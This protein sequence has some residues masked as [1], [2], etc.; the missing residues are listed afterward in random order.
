MH[1][2]LYP[3]LFFNPPFIRSYPNM[4]MEIENFPKA[5]SMLL[6]PLLFSASVSTTLYCVP[7][8]PFFFSSSAARKFNQLRYVCHPIAIIPANTLRYATGI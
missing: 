4:Q 3:V 8:K 6:F 7:S 1:P 2:C 5:S